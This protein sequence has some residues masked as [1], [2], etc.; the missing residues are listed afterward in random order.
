M[1]QQNQLYSPD[2]KFDTQVNYTNMIMTKILEIQFSIRFGKDC[3]REFSNLLF[4]LTNGIKE[5]IES[6][7]KQISLI[8]EENIKNI[9]NMKSEDYPKS[10]FKWS[11]RHKEKYR[12]ILI[13]REQSQAILEMTNII[14]NRLDEMGLLLN[15]EKKARINI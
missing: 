14:V 9:K 5:P 12:G 4:L 7:L 13:N 6:K 8:H 15:R 2:L 11:G 1:Q 10:L 3:T